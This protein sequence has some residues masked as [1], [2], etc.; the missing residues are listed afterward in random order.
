MTTI[1]DGTEQVIAFRRLA[2]TDFPV[3]G[4]W[5]AAPHVREWWNHE[6]TPEALE[7]DFGD[8]I[9]GLEAGE[10]WVAELDGRPVGLFQYSRFD[11]YPEY[12]E[13]MDDVYPVGTG[14]A[15]IDYLVGDPERIGRGLGT[16]LI[17]AFVDFAFARDPTTTHLV[18][19]VNSA[20]ERSWRALLRAGFRLV[21][22]GEMDPDNPVHE[23]MHEVLRIDRQS[24]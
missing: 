20:N 22:R 12:A 17:I 13:E 16:A 7:D 23:R 2:R 11:D 24:P 3:L 14:A 4:E 19:P 5:L 8:A 10:D 15:S 21:A 1:A 9:D 6:F 18:V